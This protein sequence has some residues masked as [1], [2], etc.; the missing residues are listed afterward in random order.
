MSTT[1]VLLGTAGWSLPREQWPEFA[2]EGT[3]LQR[4]ASRL[5]AV[6]INSAFYRPHRPATYAKWADSVPEAFRFCVKVPKQITH[7]R[8]LVDGEELLERF[9]DECG[10]LGVKLGCLLVQLPPSLSYDLASAAAFIEALR[11]RYEGPVA[12]E[13]RHA[14]WLD[15]EA[16]LQREKVARVAA[17]PAPFPEAAE[18]G[19]WAGFRY[20]R[21]HG[22]P[23]I[24]FSSYGEQWLK[25]LAER[26][27]GRSEGVTNWCI[28]DNTASG[29]ATANALALQRQIVARSN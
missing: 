9:L 26:M 5:S 19:G 14:S 21:L 16:L 28:F 3:H 1:P 10:H 7:E 8:R 11:D 25:S 6:E 15:A 23:R 27:R 12:I 24:Y 20:Y 2:A 18:P 4:Y 13:P 17:D 29:A 22:S